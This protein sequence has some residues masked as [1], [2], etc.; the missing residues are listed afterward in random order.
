MSQEE[1]KLCDMG[2]F[3]KKIAYLHGELGV[4]AKNDIAP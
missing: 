4:F 3:A 2:L 1:G